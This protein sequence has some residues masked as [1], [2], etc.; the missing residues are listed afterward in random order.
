MLT[1]ISSSLIIA[2]NIFKWAFNYLHWTWSVH[3][4]KWS[5]MFMLIKERQRAINQNML[6]VYLQMDKMK[7]GVR[8]WMSPSILLIKMIM[9]TEEEEG[10]QR[11]DWTG[12]INWTGKSPSVCIVKTKSIKSWQWNIV[13]GERTSRKDKMNKARKVHRGSNLV[14]AVAWPWPAADTSYHL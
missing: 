8:Q 12:D 1:V 13:T 11:L 2:E 14:N 10:R 4:D 9:E 5:F 3:G 6:N 7:W